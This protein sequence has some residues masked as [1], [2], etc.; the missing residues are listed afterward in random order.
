[1]K[2]LVCNEKFGIN[3]A[4][5]EAQFG[6][7]RGITPQ[8]VFLVVIIRLVKF[9]I[10]LWC[11]SQIPNAYD[12]YEVLTSEVKAAGLLASFLSHC[13]DHF[14]C[15]PIFDIYIFLQ[16]QQRARMCGG[17]GLAHN[18]MP[19]GPQRSPILVSSPWNVRFL[20]RTPPST[21]VKGEK[22]EPM[23]IEQSTKERK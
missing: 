11:L 17:A 3:C 7:G 2:N 14:L 23:G 19:T 5:A 16:Q 10:V 8:S 20:T 1:M 6:T 22:T 4:S 13:A 18:A 21:K 12:S 15:E 9:Q